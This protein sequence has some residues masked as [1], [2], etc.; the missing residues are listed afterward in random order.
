VKAAATTDAVQL[1]LAPHSSMADEPSQEWIGFPPAS[2]TQKLATPRHS[3]P[4][5]CSGPGCRRGPASDVPP[6]VPQVTTSNFVDLLLSML[7]HPQIAVPC[8]GRATPTSEPMPSS[9]FPELIEVP[10][11]NA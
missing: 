5:P 2:E 7:R 9:G 6:V 1:T 4:Q 10:P 8:S 3:L 11:E